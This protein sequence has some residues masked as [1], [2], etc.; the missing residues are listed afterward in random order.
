MK[1]LA[2]YMLL[3]LGGND[4]PT[5]EDVTKA[6]GAVGMSTDEAHLSAMM[7]ALEG[8]DFN[9]LLEEG[10]KMLA[11]F[12]GGGGGGGGGAGGAAAGG[13]GADEAKE[14]VVEEEEAPAGGGDLFGDAGGGGGTW[15]RVPDLGS[16]VENRT[17]RVRGREHPY[18]SCLCFGML[19]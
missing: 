4:E 19:V 14:E 5:Q 1:H 12:G 8:K 16:F 17:T 6:M 3:K 18:D 11:K 2:V 15:H 10:S 9:E 13:D 7:T